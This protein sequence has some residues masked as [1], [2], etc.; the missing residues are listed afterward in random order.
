MSPNRLSTFDILHLH[1][2]IEEVLPEFEYAFRKAARRGGIDWQL[3]AALAY[4]ESRWSN[5]AR[6]PTGVKGIMQLTN[7]TAKSLG[8]DD[9]MDMAQSIDAAGDYILYLKSRLPKLI[10]EP[11]R[12][13][14]AVGAYN[15]GLRHILYAYRKARSQGLQRTQWNT[16]GQLLPTLYGGPF[17]KGVQAKHYV[18]R[19]QIFTDILRF[20]DLH[21]RD[22][23]ELDLAF[24]SVGNTT[25]DAKE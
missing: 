21:Q 16:V 22:N 6:S 11:E 7:E 18:E 17:G 3:L 2:R 20:Y 10:K 4:Q 15:M 8:V 13:W 12:T 14:F 5:D 23:T 24:A 19:I 9:R 25:V 1:K